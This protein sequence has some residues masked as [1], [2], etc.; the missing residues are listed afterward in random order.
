VP[1][2]RVLIL[3]GTAEGRALA[4]ACADLPGVRTVSSL[5]GRL[6]VPVP[7]A[8]E[9]RIGGFG[10]VAGLV[11]YLREERIGAVV[12]ATHPFASTITAS[13]A[14]AAVTAGVPHAVL[15]R[16]GWTEQ[17]GDDWR[18]VPSLAD[19]ASLAPTLGQRIFLTTGRQTL[20]A[21]AGTDAWF[22]ARCVD[23][24][25]P[26]LPEKLE[27]VLDRG[28]FA[29]DGELALL[30]EH[31]ID[32][33]VTKDSGGTMA[34]AKLAAARALGLPVVM[35]DQPPPVDGATIVPSVEAA[36]AW[37]GERR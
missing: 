20:A 27:V 36:L 4:D 21:F 3:G 7:P 8:G 14:E 29:V 19:A 6:R 28:P 16:P 23:P 35:V 37:L 25:E 30:R 5:A 10:G 11:A 9:V 15:R 26:P 24:P 33:L 13:A 1:D 32:V 18:R 12:D 34:A 17:E 2:L 22:L 31:G